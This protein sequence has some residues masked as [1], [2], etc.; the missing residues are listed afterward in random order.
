MYLHP[1]IIPRCAVAFIVSGGVRLLKP[2]AHSAALWSDTPAAEVPREARPAIVPDIDGWL[3][4]QDTER[5]EFSTNVVFL[6]GFAPDTECESTNRTSNWA[7][8]SSLPAATYSS[9]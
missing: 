2:W 9:S 7:A 4:E 5:S 3:Q 6:S 8:L 1:V